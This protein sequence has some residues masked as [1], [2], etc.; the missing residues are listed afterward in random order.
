METFP[1]RVRT[2]Q[3]EEGLTRG[4]KTGREGARYEKGKDYRQDMGLNFS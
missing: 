2:I 3:R 4:A 1:S